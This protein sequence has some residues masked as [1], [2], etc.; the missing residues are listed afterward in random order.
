MERTLETGAL[1]YVMVSM[2]FGLEVILNILDLCS[3]SGADGSIG[4]VRNLN[5]F[6]R[7]AVIGDQLPQGDL[8]LAKALP[9]A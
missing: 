8:A 4:H 6:P 7:T 1:M 5:T 2:T 3:V 9:A